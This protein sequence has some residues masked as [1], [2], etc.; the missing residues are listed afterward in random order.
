[1]CEMRSNEQ[2]GPMHLSSFTDKN[3]Q[4]RIS[5]IN[6]YVNPQ[7]IQDA[8]SV[9]IRGSQSALKRRRL[10]QCEYLGMTSHFTLFQE[11]TDNLAI[12]LPHEERA[13]V[14]IQDPISNTIPIESDAVRRGAH[15]LQLLT[16]LPIYQRITEAS[17]K[18]TQESGVL[19]KPVIELTFKSLQGF[20]GSQSS[21]DFSVLLSRSREIFGLFSSPIPIHSSVSITDFMSSMSCR[22]EIIGLAFSCLGVATALPGD[23][24]S[25]VEGKLVG[26]R[27]N[28]GELALSATETCLSFCNEAGVLNDAVSWL[29]SQ[30]LFLAT[31]VHGDRDYRAWRALGDLSTIIFTL[32]LNQPPCDEDAPF[33]LVETRKRVMGSAFC[34]DKQLAT[35][36]G[37]PPRIS[38]RFCDIT[39]PLDLSFDDI[40][41]EPEVRDRAIS[42]LDADGWNTENNDTQAV[43]L[44]AY[45][46]MGPVRESILEL[47]LNQQ[48]KNLPAKIKELLQQSHQAWLSLPPF[49][50]RPQDYATY[51]LDFKQSVYLQLHLDYLYDQFLLF[52]ILSKRQNTW[53]PDL[54]KVSHEILSEVLLLIE[55]RV[56][57]MRLTPE[58]S[59]VISF[60]GL[61]SAG[62]LSIELV[63]RASQQSIDPSDPSSS[64]QS[65]SRSR[66]IQDLSI[67][68]SYLRTIVQSHEGNY[69][70]CQ[71]A[72]ETI[73]RVLDFILSSETAQPAPLNMN[74]I[75]TD[76]HSPS[77][78]D[79][80]NILDY[81]YYISHLDNWQFDLPDTLQMF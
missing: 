15:I 14:N 9:S 54:V 67:F 57:S 23:W 66:V 47:S 4:L 70:I 48:G 51:G 53:S 72:R 24:D 30:R 3:S 32:G 35:F 64:A 52:R 19:S 16:N 1:M 44:R 49:L 12:S 58:L 25:I 10:S 50:H 77:T 42:K 46:I 65:F 61:P 80:A 29:I 20:A 37:R 2:V 39:L 18:M 34:S 75:V 56:R 73:G 27:Q 71:Q 74:S 79:M 55:S 69:G 26:S 59:W 31:L 13:N 8:T 21:N 22:W 40:I 43:W 41:A 17:I 68:T 76:P 81:N 33:W 45:L 5:D 60:F 62:V 6:S 36:L 38:W 63:R 11:S 78:T 7:P 28:L